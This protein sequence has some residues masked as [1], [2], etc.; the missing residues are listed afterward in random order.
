MF[1]IGHVTEGWHKIEVLAGL[2]FPPCCA[3]SAASRGCH[4]DPDAA[5]PAEHSPLHALS[6]MRS[7]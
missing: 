5:A 4:G 7:L 1:E 3:G 2:S 6:Q